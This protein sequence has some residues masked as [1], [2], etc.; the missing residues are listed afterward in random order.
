MP[1]AYHVPPNN[2]HNDTKTETVNSRFRM[3]AMPEC[4]LFADEMN[5]TDALYHNF[6]NM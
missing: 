6:T 2:A 1:S 3:N 4:P 5:S